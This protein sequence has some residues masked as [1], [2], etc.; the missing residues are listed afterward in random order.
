MEDLKF[1]YFSK[2]GVKN[3]NKPMKDGGIIYEG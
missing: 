1:V 3:M 2:D